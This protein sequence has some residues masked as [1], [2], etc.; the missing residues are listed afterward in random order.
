MPHPLTFLRCAG[1]GLSRVLRLAC[2]AVVG[3]TLAGCYVLQAARGQAAILAKR[4]PI[5]RV[6]ARERT[7]PVVRTRLEQVI[8]IREFASRELDLPRNPS[9][10]TYTDVGR[11]YVVWNVFAAPEFSIEPL[12][13]C[14]P[15][16]GCVPYRGYFAEKSARRF[17][18]RLRHRGFD[19]YV[20]GVAAYSTLGHFSD[21]VLSTMIRFDDVELASIIFHELAHQ[22]LYIP[23]DSSFNEAFA[24]AVEQEG[25]RRWLLAANRPTELERFAA[26][27][28]HL[29]AVNGELAR[30]R[31]QLQSSYAQPGAVLRN[32]DATRVAKSD[33]LASLTTRLAALSAGW[34]DGIDYAAW[35]SGD[36]NNARL[37][38][39]ATYIDCVPGFERLLA[40]S[41]G[42]LTVFYDRVRAL[43][44]R[45]AEERRA[46]LCP[47]EVRDAA[48]DVQPGNE[49]AVSE[50]R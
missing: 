25:V 49:Q 39:I 17:A 11:P 32:A 7:P 46:V 20:G 5:D 35:F 28:H 2:G 45:P 12:R 16:A 9:Y 48:L 24:T 23:G 40:A 21:P 44:D 50:Q 3:T 42:D 22:R 37:A 19:V 18:D 30:T 13:W 33:A 29:I 47:A 38:S 43:G 8:G 26:R 41:G 15:I 36:L 10:T 34:R 27:R 1:R 14:F 6:V 4:E 31:A